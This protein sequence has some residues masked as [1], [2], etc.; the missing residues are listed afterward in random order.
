MKELNLEGWGAN[1]FGL[2]VEFPIHGTKE[3][4][5]LTL[6]SLALP[7]TSVAHSTH[8]SLYDTGLICKPRA[9]GRQW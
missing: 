7:P 3:W 2:L 9:L 4:P 6:S 5:L 8:A 1:P